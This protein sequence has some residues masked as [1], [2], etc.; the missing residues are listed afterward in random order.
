MKANYKCLA[1]LALIAGIFMGPASAFAWPDHPLRMI[2]PF[3]AGGST[4]VTA[5]LLAEKL[6]VALGQPVVVENRPGAGGNIASSVVAKA[7]PDG[8]TLLMATSTTQVTNPNLYS[9]LPFDPVKDL[10]P[11]SQTAFIP[12]VL[13]VSKSL[14]VNDL[15]EFIAYAKANPGKLNY[16]SAGNGSSLHLAGELFKSL[17]KVDMVHVPYGGSAPA[18]RDL[19]TGNIQA[20]FSP[21]VDAIPF[22]DAGTFKALAVTTAGRTPLYPDLPAVAEV[23]PDYEITLWN[24]VLTTAGAPQEIIDRISKE[25]VAILN[26][27]E[28]KE[29]FAKQGSIPVGTNPKEFAEF[30]DKELVKWGKIV[31]IS[32][33]HID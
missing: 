4:D 26:T 13:V 17:A 6:A 7:D 10:A 19:L 9:K 33:A 22:I 11:I 24:G 21:L 25:L 23:I 8:Y 27:P 29:K 1:G 28:M 2:V 18:L 5:R 32:G 12:N 16:G 30:I 14:P 15:K 20:V 3:S 31:K